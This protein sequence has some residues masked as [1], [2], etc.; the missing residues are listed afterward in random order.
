MASAGS[1]KNL[2]VVVLVQGKAYTWGKGEYNKLK[3]DDLMV[4]SRPR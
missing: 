4:F 1:G 2:N 3:Y